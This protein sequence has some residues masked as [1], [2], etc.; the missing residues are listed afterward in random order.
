MPPSASFDVS[1][2]QKAYCIVVAGPQFLKDHS[3][4]KT[5]YADVQTANAAAAA[6]LRPLIIA[7]LDKWLASGESGE[8]TADA[9]RLSGKLNSPQVFRYGIA[10]KV[11]VE[12]KEIWVLEREIKVEV[13]SGEAAKKRKKRDAGKALDADEWE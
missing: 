4:T 5:T 1:R 10:G 11:R 7:K 3:S 2:L 13:P 12:V 8:F 6:M 9:D